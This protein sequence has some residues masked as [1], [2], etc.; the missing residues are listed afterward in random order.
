MK[1]WK[2]ILTFCISFL[3]LGCYEVNEAISINENGSGRYV[4]KMDMGQMIE[5]LQSMGGDE[6]NKEGLDKVVDTVIS[7][8]SFTDTMKDAKPEVKELMKNGKLHLV[9]NLKEKIFKIDT[10]IP[11]NNY[12]QLQ[13]I[14]SGNGS[15]M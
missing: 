3:L 15:G 6:M 9:M 2:F 7:M 11:F 5:M 4:T 10:D 8:G 1:P 13:L 14:L 12:E